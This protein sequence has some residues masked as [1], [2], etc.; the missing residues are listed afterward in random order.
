[1][2]STSS[3]ESRTHTPN[4]RQFV[5]GYCELKKLS[6][7]PL[8]VILSVQIEGADKNDVHVVAAYSDETFDDQT[9]DKVRSLIVDLGFTETRARMIIEHLN[10]N[11]IVF[12][13]LL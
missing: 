1:M 2:T 13:E 10:G 7:D 9:L 8:K 11:G 4:T 12:R 5:L 6:K 3:I